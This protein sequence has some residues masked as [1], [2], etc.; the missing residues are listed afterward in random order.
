MLVRSTEMVFTGNR[1]YR[2]DPVSGLTAPFEYKLKEGKKLP[3][4]YHE[5]TPGAAPAKVEK[6]LI[7]PGQAAAPVRA[8]GG[9][10]SKREIMAELSA[11]GV[12]YNATMKAGDLLKIL[13]EH[14]A[15]AAPAASTA[16]SKAIA[17]GEGEGE[18]EGEGAPKGSGD[19]DVI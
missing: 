7:P 2:V 4:H 19:V 3:A 10:L 6:S 15:Q 5:V 13:N 18:G 12:K 8:G 9:E 1:R 16:P 17:P 14:K 11:A